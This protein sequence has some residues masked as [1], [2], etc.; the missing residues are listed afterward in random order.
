MGWD[1]LSFIPVSV[2][3]LHQFMNKFSG[4]PV[5]VVIVSVA[6]K[7]SNYLIRDRYNETLN[8]A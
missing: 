6:I 8:H 5:P 1:Q 4:L 7:H 2:N 3:Q